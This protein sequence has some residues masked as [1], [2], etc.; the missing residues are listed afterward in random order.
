MT[1]AQLPAK[2]VPNM[3]FLQVKPDADVRFGDFSKWDILL[4]LPDNDKLL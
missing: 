3:I 2:P 1:A 4:I